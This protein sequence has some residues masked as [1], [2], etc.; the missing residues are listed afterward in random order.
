MTLQACQKTLVLCH[1]GGKEKSL[2]GKKGNRWVSQRK[3]Q[4][5]TSCKQERNVTCQ[6]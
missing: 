3:L 4:G 1:Q 6:S 2:S 5:C